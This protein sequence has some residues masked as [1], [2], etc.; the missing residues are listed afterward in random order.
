M[1]ELGAYCA[2]L[3]AGCII[4]WLFCYDNPRNG[5]ILPE[6]LPVKQSVWDVP[7]N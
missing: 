5:L 4:E 3:N 2:A 6:L 1:P 7:E